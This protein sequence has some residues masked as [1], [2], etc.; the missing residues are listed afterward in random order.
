V[1]WLRK[2]L[3]AALAALSLG[4]SVT[5]ENCQ[6]ADRTMMAM[7]ALKET[8]HLQ[9]KD[10]SD[11]V[12]EHW[13]SLGPFKPDPESSG[14][15]V[16][17]VS[18]SNGTALFAMQM[19][20]PIPEEDWTFACQTSLGWENSCSA[21]RQMKGHVIVSVLHKADLSVAESTMLVSAFVQAVSAKSK[22]IGIFLGQAESI[23]SA[24]QWELA[25]MTASVEEPPYF[26]WI[27]LKTQKEESGALSVVTMGMPAFDFMNIEI[28][29]SSGD[30]W[31]TVQLV[32]DA[33]SYL[34]KGGRAI[35]DGDTVGFSAE[36]KI[37]V[38]HEP[39][40]L[41]SSSTVYRLHY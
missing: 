21:F 41:D 25:V 29:N 10:L 6:A 28:Q 16:I 5:S 37:R 14:S 33:A 18:N 24:E 40:M 15:E 35:E 36:Q 27:G 12:N 1:S 7:V 19:D 2:T 13:P 32:G 22:S 34:I 8:H 4:A 30:G 38:T 23:W 31:E 20:F 26:P 3:Q 9:A 11:Y 39:S 17:S